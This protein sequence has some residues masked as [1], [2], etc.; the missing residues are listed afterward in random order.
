LNSDI[1]PYAGAGTGY[2]VNVGGREIPEFAELGASFAT[3][4]GSTVEILHGTP[5]VPLS[6]VGNTYIASTE[7]L[8]G[9]GTAT[10]SN[11]QLATGPNHASNAANY[12][13]GVL[14]VDNDTIVFDIDLDNGGV[15]MLYD[16]DYFDGAAVDLNWEFTNDWTGQAGLAPQNENGYAEYRRRY[17]LIRGGSKTVKLLP[18]SLGNINCGNLYLDATG[19]AFQSWDLLVAR[20]AQSAVPSVYITGGDASGASYMNIKAGNVTIEPADAPD[21]GG[22]GFLCVSWFIGQSGATATDPIVTIGPNVDFTEFDAQTFKQFSGTVY[23]YSTMYSDGTHETGLTI[24][25]GVFEH[26]KS[27]NIGEVTVENGGTFRLNTAGGEAS[28]QADIVI[29]AGGTFDLSQC[30]LYGP[31]A[32]DVRLFA[33]STLNY[34]TFNGLEVLQYVGCRQSDVAGTLPANRALDLSTAA[35]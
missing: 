8:A 12:L 17:L 31:V 21:A 5:G 28:Q 9:N 2:S 13:G 34:P 27:G 26:R 14:P 23:N 33:K 4:V 32:G 15:D 35:V 29:F 19:Q 22:N 3:A 25:G 16:L 6:D 7:T 11:L 10:L 1:H 24:A 20:N 18:G 30:P